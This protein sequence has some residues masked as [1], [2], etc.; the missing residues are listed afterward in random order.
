MRP[1]KISEA[2]CKRSVLK[3]LLRP[4]PRVIQGAGIGMDYGAVQF[5]YGKHLITSMAT[6]RLCTYDSER[7]AFWKA[8]NKLETSGTKTMAI[9]ANVLLPARGNESR[10]K[11]ITGN[12]AELC[13]QYELEYIGG[14]TELMEE[15][16]APVI[17]IIAYGENGQS[18]YSID[19]IKAGEAILMV[20]YAGTEATVMLVKDKW[21]E[22][23]TR[24]S[25]SYLQRA[26]DME[27]RLSLREAFQAL[28]S[29]PVT[30]IHDISTGG[31]FAALWEVGE[32]AGCGIEVML[33]AIPIRQETIEICEFFDINPYMAFGGGSA[34]VITPKPEQVI[35]NLQHKG[36]FVRMIGQT[37]ASNDRIVLNEDDSRYLTLP[38]GDDTYKIYMN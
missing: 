27:H 5:E 12:L 23:H 34:L 36:I 17:T 30:Y 16:R 29:E 6:C 35:E 33:K 8:L 2:Q 19:N 1:G 37:T 18:K 25:A 26:R 31:V 28:E 21:E 9:M 22:L 32:G 20:G 15:L 14:H 11:E 24:Y 7:Y 10:I 38:K 4:G 3:K 13:K